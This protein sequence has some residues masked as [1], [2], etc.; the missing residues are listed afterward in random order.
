MAGITKYAMAKKVLEKYKGQSFFLEIL[1]AIIS[2][3]LSS[4]EKNILS[5]LR[6]MRD[7]KLIK[8]VFVREGITKWKVM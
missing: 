2:K 7:N 3:E 8:E 1:K 6:L 4:D 5:Y